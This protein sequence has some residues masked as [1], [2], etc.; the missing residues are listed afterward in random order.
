MLIRDQSVKSTQ[1]DKRDQSL[2]NKFSAK[3]LSELILSNYGISEDVVSDVNLLQ[4][5]KWKI[6]EKD[7]KRERYYIMLKR[8][9]K[10]KA[11]PEDINKDSSLDDFFSNSIISNFLNY[12][13]SKTNDQFIND[14]LKEFRTLNLKKTHQKIQPT[15]FSRLQ[16]DVKKRQ[17]TT[18]S[19]NSSHN[20]N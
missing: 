11:R 6:N 7:S 1:Q 15:V 19:P 4:S 16:K 2:L 17:T 12:L 3:D 13:L 9:I 20:I 8:I 18:L 14:K 5:G 10:D